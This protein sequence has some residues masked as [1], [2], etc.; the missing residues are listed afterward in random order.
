MRH[1][2]AIA[3]P[4]RDDVSPARGRQD[5]RPVRGGKTGRIERVVV[6]RPVGHDATKPYSP[7]SSTNGTCRRWPPRT[8]VIITCSPGRLLSMA[9]RKSSAVLTGLPST[10]T[11][12][13]AAERS[14]V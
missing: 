1:S 7:A 8:T 9:S 14:T 6:G 13:S 4:A 11:I 3:S 5:D 2:S 12:R 10:P